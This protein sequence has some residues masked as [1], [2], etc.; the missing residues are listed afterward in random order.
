VISYGAF[1]IMRPA[2]INFAFCFYYLP[3]MHQ[4]MQL[5]FEKTFNKEAGVPLSDSKKVAAS[6]AEKI[7]SAMVWDYQSE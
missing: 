3:D 5:F 7:K 4:S 6:V 1:T 2:G